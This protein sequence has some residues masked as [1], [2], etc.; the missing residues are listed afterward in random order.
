M[1]SKCW[2]SVSNH[3]KVTFDYSCSIDII[4]LHCDIT[5]LYHNSL[6]SQCSTYYSQIKYID[7]MSKVWPIKTKQRTHTVHS[8]HHISILQSLSD[9]LVLPNYKISYWFTFPSSFGLT[10]LLFLPPGSHC[11]VLNSCE[12]GFNRSCRMR[13]HGSSLPACGLFHFL[14][15][16]SGLFSLP[17]MTRF[18]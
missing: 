11:S 18:C 14:W 5:L 6:T 10:S 16:A 1:T 7:L 4:A 13:Y 3:L 15:W 2:V 9:F 12:I 17:Q 8:I